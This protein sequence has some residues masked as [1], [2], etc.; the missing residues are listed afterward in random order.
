MLFVFDLKMMDN[1]VVVAK[2]HAA[3]YTVS[4]MIGMRWDTY[5]EIM[6]QKSVNDGEKDGAPV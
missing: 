6:P 1:S 3:N 5:R 4:G 2:C